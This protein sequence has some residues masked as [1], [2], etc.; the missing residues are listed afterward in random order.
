[1]KVQQTQNYKPYFG[2]GNNTV[3]VDKGIKALGKDIYYLS[4]SAAK[5]LAKTSEGFPKG[6]VV[7]IERGYDTNVSY[8]M[9]NITNQ[10]E[11]NVWP[12][13]NDKVIVCVEHEAKTRL[14]K[15]AKFFGIG[16]ISKSAEITAKI[17][18][19]EGIIAAGYKALSLV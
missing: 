8:S 7:S 17:P 14:Q 2:I 15:L 12:T 13:P 11:P 6:L 9:S 18:N 19:E 5:G 4:K 1:M 16:K 10:M 3:I